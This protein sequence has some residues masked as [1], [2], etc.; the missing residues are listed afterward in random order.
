MNEIE[1]YCKRMGKMLASSLTQGC[2][3]VSKVSKLYNGKYIHKVTA[4]YMRV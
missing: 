4:Q 1:H 3:N 2:G